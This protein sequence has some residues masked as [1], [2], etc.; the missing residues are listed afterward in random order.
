MP[1]GSPSQKD[2]PPRNFAAEGHSLEGGLP[3][4]RLAITGNLDEQTG[5]K[6][7]VAS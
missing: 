5:S 6:R 2:A 4:Q 7:G 1:E 3:E